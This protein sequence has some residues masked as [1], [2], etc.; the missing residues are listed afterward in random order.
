MIHLKALAAPVKL[1]VGPRGGTRCGADPAGITWTVTAAAGRVRGPRR[2]RRAG[3]RQDVGRA[4]RE[5]LRHLRRPAAL[6]CSSP[7]PTRSGISGFTYARGSFEFNEYGCP[8]ACRERL[9]LPIAFEAYLLGIGEM[10]SSWPAGGPAHAGRRGAHLRHVRSEALRAACELQ[11]QPH[12]RR[13]RPDLRR[14]R[15]G[16]AAPTARGGRPRSRRR[17]V[18]SSPIKGRDPVVLRR[19]RRRPL[20][21]HRGRMVRREPRLRRPL[22][23]RAS[24]IPASTRR[25]TRGRTGGIRT[26]KPLSRAACRRTPADRHRD[27]VPVV[28]HA[29]GGQ[30][31]RATVQG[32]S[33]RATVSGMELRAALGPARGPGVD[34]RQQEHPGSGAREIRRADVRAGSAAH[35]RLLAA[36]R[37]SPAIRRGRHLPQRPA[38]TSRCG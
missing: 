13:E 37:V 35:A 1:W 33:G 15:Q 30:I 9:I 11:L 5:P 18:R 19:L 10:P 34:R 17:P 22:P 38:P 26:R 32:T 27:G 16:R 20:R 4:G 12:R 7:R 36:G 28:V 3:G 29:E 2:A 6:A 23:A 8:S 24:A 31:L 21:E 25:R 14:V